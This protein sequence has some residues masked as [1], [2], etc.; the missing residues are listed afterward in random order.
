MS[1]THR[2]I[3]LGLFERSLAA[4]H[5]RAR[6]RAAAARLPQ[7]AD[8][9]VFALGKAAS[10]MT[11]GALDCLGPR[12][13]ESLVVS[14]D[15]HFD[16]ELEG[17]AGVTCLA[18]GHPVPDERSLAAGAELLHRLARLTPEEKVL[19]LV[20]GG[21]SSLVEALPNGV[22]LADLR[23][24]NEWGLSIGLDIVGLNRI[25]KALS[26]IKG[27]RLLQ[28]LSGLDVHALFISDVPGDDPSVIGSGILGAPEPAIGPGRMPAWVQ[29]LMKCAQPATIPDV[30]RVERQV[31]AKLDDALDALRGA[32]EDLGLKVAVHPQRFAGDARHLAVGFAHELVMSPVDLNVWGGESTVEL[33]AEPGRG[34]RNQHLALAAAGLLTGHDDI[35]IL[36]AGTDGTDGPT[37]D[38]GALVDGSTLDRGTIAG[39]DAEDCLARC[40]AGSFLEASGDLVSTGP[41]GTNVGDLVLGLRLPRGFAARQ[42]PER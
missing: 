41:T 25:R 29:K 16:V 12:V 42:G 22:T 30:L 17:T 10:A 3:L 20:S 19:F 40:D 39:F 31:I 4:V 5:G 36:A 7:G 35:A 11:L 32:A 9:R 18:S 37:P 13:I 1:G 2:R 24:V 38:A 26:L 27:G 28:K 21:A 6:T 15:G 33:P 14:K 34:G 8:W 23:R